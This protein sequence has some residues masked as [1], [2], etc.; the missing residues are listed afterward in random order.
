MKESLVLQIQET[1]FPLKSYSTSVSPE[2]W[3]K[4]HSFS[5]VIVTPKSRSIIV[6]SFVSPIQIPLIK[7]VDALLSWEM[8]KP[9]AILETL[10]LE[11]QGLHVEESLLFGDLYCS[12]WCANHLLLLSNTINP[13]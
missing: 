10:L 4:V 12:N 5:E 13:L 6:G 2:F 9:D 8:E 11:I 3:G 1:V 7:S